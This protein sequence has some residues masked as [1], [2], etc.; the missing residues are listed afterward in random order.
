MPPASIGKLIL[1]RHGETE[2]NRLR[3]FGQDDILLTDTGRA[4]ARELALRIAREFHPELLLSS[5]FARAIETSQIIAAV[6]ELPIQVLSG[7][8]ERDFGCLKGHS[9]GRMG[10]LMIAD[11]LYDPAKTWLWTPADG[12][13]MDDVRERAMAALESVRTEYAGREILVVCHGAV[14]QSV[15]AHITGEWSE[16]FIPPNCGIVVLEHGE[17]GWQSPHVADTWEEIRA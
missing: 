4:Q 12:E 8:H 15:C 3:C 17:E 14:I 1:V 16:T 6:L 11:A 7:I 13:S 10:E 2:A 9:Y 5:P